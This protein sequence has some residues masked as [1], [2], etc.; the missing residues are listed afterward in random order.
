MN[1]RLNFSERWSNSGRSQQGQMLRNGF[2]GLILALCLT[3]CQKSNTSES[4]SIKEPKIKNTGKDMP[5]CVLRVWNGSDR[6]EPPTGHAMRADF[7]PGKVL[8]VEVK[9]FNGWVIQKT[10][11][12]GYV[13]HALLNDLNPKLEDVVRNGLLKEACDARHI[14]VTARAGKLDGGKTRQ[15][16]QD[17]VI[18]N[19]D[20]A[21][22]DS[23]IQKLAPTQKPADARIGA[24]DSQNQEINAVPDEFVGAVLSLDKFKK[25]SK[26]LTGK[27]T[28]TSGFLL[29]DVM[30]LVQRLKAQKGGEM[31]LRINGID[32]V[33]IHA[34]NASDE[35]QTLERRWR[36]S[37]YNDYFWFRFHLEETEQNQS[38]WQQLRGGCL[39]TTS[40]AVTLTLHCPFEEVHC[41]TD[42]GV[43]LQ[44]NLSKPD[45]G[46]RTLHLQLVNDW[47][48]ILALL[49]LGVMLWIFIHFALETDL[50]RDLQATLRPDGVAPYGLARSQM[51][52]WFILVV[53][54]F[55]F[56]WLYQGE[57]PV[58]NN[59]C[60]V[61][62][63]IGAGTALGS[64]MISLEASS[65]READ[66]TTAREEY[67]DATKGM[68]TRN[69]NE[70][71]KHFGAKLK[72][73]I[74]EIQEQIQA[75]EEPARA[76]LV[77]RERT[78]QQQLE[79]FQAQPSHRLHRLLNDWLSDENHYSFHR[80]QMLIWTIILGIIFA[81]TVIQTRALPEF[82]NTLLALLGISNGTYLGFRL[83]SARS[84]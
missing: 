47:H 33:G 23:S 49:G 71:R 26:L 67:A 21:K 12:L 58:L 64:A 83:P 77:K 63:G 27:P 75:T 53:A 72:R 3:Q 79:A 16:V 66:E 38:A 84:R 28:E 41:L 48:L 43:V 35:G 50:I 57:I 11:E 42:T 52:F 78:L 24:T 55:L 73:I 37:D 70:P 31:C 68:V 5:S 29:K 74:K 13:S 40:R 4:T 17:D 6:N 39:F 62:I 44:D 8:M 80:Y 34:E 32:F 45:T 18:T 65:Q 81:V 60:L 2:C 19:G 22:L 51:A 7:A 20:K 76:E 10:D 69:A 59:T 56:L 36:D 9:N 82:D 54:A 14:L 15:W 46:F 1:T 25:L 61:L 30:M